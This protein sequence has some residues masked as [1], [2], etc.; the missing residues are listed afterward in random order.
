MASNGL[1]IAS[2][3]QQVVSVLR[4]LANQIQAM[5]D[6]D[7]ESVLAGESRLEIRPPL[8]KQ[9]QQRARMRCSEEEFERLEEALRSTQTRERARELIDRFLHTK[10]DLTRFA[11]V[12]DI[13]VPRSTSSEHL[14]DRL[15]EGTVGYRLR[16]AAIRGKATTY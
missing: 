7:F 2:P 1:K 8:K 12:L 16:S 11:R 10:A 6:S 4:D 14:K 13:P 5:D 3:K 15:V 9:E